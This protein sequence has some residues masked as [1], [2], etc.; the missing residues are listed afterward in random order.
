MPSFRHL[1]ME[2]ASMWL[3]R[4]N[5]SLQFRERRLLVALNVVPD[6]ALSALIDLV[7]VSDVFSTIQPRPRAANGVMNP[8]GC[9]ESAIR[10]IMGGTPL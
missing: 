8:P 2:A 7:V 5:S 6:C 9:G 3:A 4:L 10:V 1:A